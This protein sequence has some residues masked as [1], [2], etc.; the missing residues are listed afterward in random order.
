MH[1]DSRCVV[2]EINLYAVLTRFADGKRKIG[3]VHFNG[4]VVHH[5]AY[6]DFQGALR[7]L[8]L[9]NSVIEVKQRH[10]GC[11]AQAHHR[12]ADLQLGPRV[13]GCPEAVAIG[14]WPVDGGLQPIRRTSG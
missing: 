3:R 5:A 10:T 13:G 4:L 1:R 6:P 14:Q 12:A 11:R 9:G 8:H 2:V 7:K